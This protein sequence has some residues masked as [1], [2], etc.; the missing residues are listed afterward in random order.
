MQQVATSRFSPRFFL[1]TALLA[2]VLGWAGS[3]RADQYADV[4]A[5]LR[6]GRASEALA[7][8]DA[9]VA[10]NP[11]D[12]QMRFLKGVA[13]NDAGQQAEAVATFTKLIE[14]YPELP[15]PYNNLAV[16]YASQNQLDK[17]RTALEMAVRNNPAY[18][19]AHENLGDVYARLANQSYAKAQQL[20]PAGASV[21]PK[22]ALLREL[23]QPPAP[24][25]K[26][27]P[28]GSK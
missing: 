7:K 18:A 19:V 24:A 13:Q 10:T 8:A 27:A 9:Y 22:L 17:A 21:R 16:I 5:L 23:F 1:F 12:P 25:A 14:E 3:A 20:D 6:Q 2:L 28:R 15:E 11:R 26:R 4:N